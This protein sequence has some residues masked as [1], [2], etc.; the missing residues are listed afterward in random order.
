MNQIVV[1]NLRDY[2]PL[3]ARTMRQGDTDE[4]AYVNWALGLCGELAELL[5]EIEKFGTDSFSIERILKEVGDCF[6]YLGSICTTSRLSL[7]EVV[8]EVASGHNYEKGVL[9]SAAVASSVVTGALIQAGLFSDAV[10][11]LFFHAHDPAVVVGKIPAV[12]RGIAERLVVLCGLYGSDLGP[13]LTA[14]VRK[15]A[16][17][18]P[19]GFDTERSKKRVDSDS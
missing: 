4:Y 13:V 10:K 16:A 1:E 2:Q 7:H 3:A 11:K 17:R 5:Q 18:Y 8:G 9:P 12:V 14:N 15:L 6:W 19:E